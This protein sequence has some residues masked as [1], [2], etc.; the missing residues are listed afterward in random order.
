[1]LYKDS[2]LSDAELLSAADGE[3]TAR[4]QRQ[5][6]AHLE[7]CWT[8]RTRMAELEKTISRFVTNYRSVFDPQLPPG[9][10]ATRRLLARVTQHSSSEVNHAP[11][12]SMA[13]LL[14]LRWAALTPLLLFVL[15]SAGLFSRK[16]F[17]SSSR[18]DMRPIA[19]TPIIPDHHLTPGEAA[20]LSKTDVCEGNRQKE[21]ERRIPENLRQAVLAEYGVKGAPQE[22]YEVDFL[23]TPELGGST[24]LRN[25]WPQP[26]FGRTW[27]ARV[28]DALEERLHTL[29]CSGDL[30][31][32]TAQREIA[33]NWVDAYQKYVR[34]DNPM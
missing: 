14:R 25:L 1:M 6:R 24:S 15:L 5:V 12:F 19:E 16:I 22:D 9:D 21:Q 27:N 3:L 28:K 13:M 29:V 32:S 8:C 20:L 18:R 30:D 7:T 31:L 23:I 11:F 34:T 10:G 26:Y 33:T 2:H 17:E 4:R